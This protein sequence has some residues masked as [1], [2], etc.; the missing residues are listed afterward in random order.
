M[1]T[2]PTQ[3]ASFQAMVY[4]LF[5]R[6]ELSGVVA[7]VIDPPGG[8]A[9]TVVYITHLLPAPDLERLVLTPLAHAPVGGPPAALLRSGRFP[10]AHLR[11]TDQ[12]DSLVSGLMGGLAALH[13]DGHSEV[14]LI[15]SGL[16]TTLEN[17]FGSGLDTNVATLHRQLRRDD[18]QTEEHLR[19][20]GSRFSLVYL[21]SHAARK[22]VQAARTWGLNLSPHSGRQPWW[23][24]WLDALRLPPVLESDSPAA[25]AEALTNGYVA[26]FKDNYRHPLVAPTTLDMLFSSSRDIS[27]RPAIR[28]LTTGPRVLAATF[29]LTLSAGFVAISS[30]H[31]SLMPGPFLVALTASRANLPFPVIGEI[32]LA[33]LLSDSFQAAAMRTG[34]RRL[35]VAALVATLIALMALMQVGILGGVSGAVG[36][37][38]SAVRATL[39]NPALRRV[40]R[41]WR[42]FFIGAAVGLG[43]YGMTLLLFVMMI[44]LAEERALEHPVRLPPAGVSS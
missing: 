4:A 23:R 28:R 8:L 6:P 43:V 3:Q 16:H 44:Y 42:Y 33:A 17:S 11:L 9:V 29:G 27:Q 34:G 2:I 36:I 1:Y 25:L 10:A 20:D 7:R 12:S 35:T 19:A 14:L 32:L 21:K 37:V 26:V 31:H 39:P 30:Y 5:P 18:L 13:V 15:G 41:L 22:T 38:E 24:T 40:I